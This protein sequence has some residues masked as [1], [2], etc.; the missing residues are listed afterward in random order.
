MSP[1][2]RKWTGFATLSELLHKICWEPDSFPSSYP[3]FSSSFIL[4]LKFH[5]IRCLKLMMIKLC[6]SSFREWLTTV[7]EERTWSRC[8]REIRHTKL[9]WASSQSLLNQSIHVI[10]WNCSSKSGCWQIQPHPKTLWWWPPKVEN[11][12][13][14]PEL[15][16]HN[17]LYSEMILRMPISSIFKNENFMTNESNWTWRH[18]I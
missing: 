6:I 18:M 8:S 12:S 14:L 13:L 17:S 11:Q 15:Q 4:L 2:S 7:L 10:S 1:A 9:P 3:S 16:L 5:L